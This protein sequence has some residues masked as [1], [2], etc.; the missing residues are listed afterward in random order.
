MPSP[1][2][3][4]FPG[5]LVRV[6]FVTQTG[7]TFAQVSTYWH[8]PTVGSVGPADLVDLATAYNARL[9]VHLQAI[10]SPLTTLM[11]LYLAEVA[12]GTC[13]SAQF[14][15]AGA[16]VG[17]A[18]ASPLPME[19]AAIMSRYS[20]LKG[21]HGRGRMFWPAVPNTFVTAATD[22]DLLNAAALTAYAAVEADLELSLVAGAKVWA[23]F[24]PTTPTPP[25]VVYSQG[26]VVTRCTTNP[27]LGTCRRRKKGRGI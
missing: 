17:T 5:S 24:L 9:K 11:W 14:N 27:V 6:G 20:G 22:A 10:L 2:A 23:P 4:G 1:P 19:V 12:Y 3:P 26:V 13:P 21:K 8:D 25:S 7:A 15:Y 18:G 16:T